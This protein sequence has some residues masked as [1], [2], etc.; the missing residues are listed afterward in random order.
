MISIYDS[1]PKYISW[2][3]KRPEPKLAK[4]ALL[5]LKE[6][7]FKR[8]K[9]NIVIEDSKQFFGRICWHL[10]QPEKEENREQFATDL[11]DIVSTGKAMF[12]T[13][14]LFNAGLG[15]GLGLSAC[16]ILEPEDSLESIMQVCKD[17][18]LIQ[19][20][21][22]GVGYNFSKLRPK[23][24]IVA[25]CNAT[26]DGPLPFIDM[27]CSTTSAIQ[28]GAKRRGAQMGMLGIHH[29]DIWDFI[30]AKSNLDRWQNMNVSPK[31]SDTWMEQATGKRGELHDVFHSKWGAGHLER[32]PDGTVRSKIGSRLNP[33]HRFITKAE[34]FDEIC[35]LAWENGEPGLYFEDRVNKDW[36]FKKSRLYPIIATNPCGEIPGENGM[37]CNLASMNL[38]KCNTAAEQERVTYLMIRALDNVVEMNEFAVKL[39]EEINKA[40]RR[41]GFGVMGWADYLFDKRIPYNSEEARTEAEVIMERIA[42]WS[43]QESEKLGKEKGNFGAFEQSDYPGGFHTHMRNAYRNMHAPTGT[44]SIIADCSCGIEPIYSLAFQREVLEDAQGNRKVMTEVNKEFKQ[45]VINHTEKHGPIS[46]EKPINDAAFSK[47][48]EA[49]AKYAS[50]NGSIQGYADEWTDNEDWNRI[51]KVFVTA[52]DVAVEDHIKMQAAWQKFTDQAISKT[53]NLNHDATVEDVKKAYTLAW[54]LGCK[55]I[56]VY[57]DG[58]R[59]GRSGQVQPMKLTKKQPE[60]KKAVLEETDDIANSKRIRQNTPLGKLHVNVVHDNEGTP[61]EIFAQLS[62]AGELATADLEAICRLS[63]LWLRSGGSFDILIKQLEHLGSSVM[64][65]TKNGKIKSLPDGMAVALKRF[66]KYMST[67]KNDFKQTDQSSDYVKPKCPDCGS[68]L[69]KSEGCEACT[70]PACGYSK[71]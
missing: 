40:T 2:L 1:D 56:T 24:S 51:R 64:L 46:S 33:D 54:Q 45:A 38:A 34:L 10:A 69:K 60:E 39:I 59:D 35:K 67:G 23:G 66:K 17:L 9:H 57:R 29:P 5:V 3:D 68:D 7:Y 31:V 16:Y 70:N 53:I 62:K 25:S 47:R 42:D 13:P 19:K 52:K 48:M 36:I 27:Y 58:C 15:N 8:D 14:T 71:C 49:I 20:S 37:T 43:A 22:G 21:G 28:Q 11:Y 41:I 44:I 6:R 55:G 18:A 61:K 4:N 50:E 26:T 12:N 32:A 30:H 65:P 63:S